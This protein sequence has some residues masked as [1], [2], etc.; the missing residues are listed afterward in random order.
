[1]ICVPNITIITI[2]QLRI[3]RKELQDN[4]VILNYSFKIG[5]IRSKPNLLLP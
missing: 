1:M 2:N 4:Y 5:T 3:I